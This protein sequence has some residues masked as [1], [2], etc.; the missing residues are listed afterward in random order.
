MKLWLD[1]IRKPWMHGCIGFEWAKTVDEAIALLKT[2]RVT[3][4]SLD[5]DLSEKGL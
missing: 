3:F 4:A 1:D 5:H 2:G